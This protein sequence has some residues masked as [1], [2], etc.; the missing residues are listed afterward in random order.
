MRAS[1]GQKRAKFDRIRD[2]CLRSKGQCWSNLGQVWSILG[3]FVCQNQAQV[4]HVRT[5]CDRS[6][7]SFGRIRRI[8]GQFKSSSGRIWSILC[9]LWPKLAEPDPNFVDSGPNWLMLVGIVLKSGTSGPNSTNVGS[10]SAKFDPR[11]RPIWGNFNELS[12]FGQKSACNPHSQT[13]IE[14]RSAQTCA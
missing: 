7:A 10:A 12:R 14:Q 6:Q 3:R 1:C 9:R 13:L 8:V 11:I 4:G 5:T 2:M